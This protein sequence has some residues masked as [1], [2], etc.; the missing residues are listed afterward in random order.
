MTAPINQQVPIAARIQIV[1]LANGEVQCQANG[2]REPIFVGLGEAVKMLALQLSEQERR[3]I[4]IAPAMP[5]IL[6]P[7]G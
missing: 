2:T 4:Q 7:E 3:K 6:I 1:V 5:G